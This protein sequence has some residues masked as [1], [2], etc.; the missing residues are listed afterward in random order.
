MTN[1]GEAVAIKL[2][3]LNR[4]VIGD[5]D[6]IKAMQAVYAE[7]KVR[8]LRGER[9]SYSAFERTRSI[10]KAEKIIDRDTD[11]GRFWRVP[12]SSRPANLEMRS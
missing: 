3:K 1:L 10:L 8:Y 11:Y 5:I 7:G 2:R 4:P 6:I 12:L 9:P